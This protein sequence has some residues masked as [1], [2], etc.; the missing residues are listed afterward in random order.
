MMDLSWNLMT[1]AFNKVESAIY[2]LCNVS[3]SNLLEVYLSC[4]HEV[5][6]LCFALWSMDLVLWCIVRDVVNCVPVIIV[7]GFCVLRFAGFYLAR[8]SG[9]RVL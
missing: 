8:L 7:F 4:V 1:E 6:T 3:V 9:I 5:Y 2:R